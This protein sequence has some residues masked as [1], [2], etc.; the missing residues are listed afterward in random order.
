MAIRA[1]ILLYLFVI[2]YDVKGQG[3]RDSVFE[4]PQVHVRAE[5]IF[6]KESAGMRQ[7]LID[8]LTM[9]QKVNASLSELLSENTSVF[10]KNHGRGALATASFR[11]TAPSH[12]GVSWNGIN[13]SS[14]MTGM[15]DFALVPVYIMDE[16]HLKHGTASIAD[17]AGG[18]GGSISIS[19]RPD[20]DNTFST[21]YTQGIGSYKTYKE[22]LKVE[23]GNQEVQLRT[24]AYHNQSENNYTFLNR[25]IAD[26]E[27]GRVTHPVDTNTHADYKNYGLLQEVYLRPGGNHLVS[28]RWWGQWAQRTLPRATSF[29]GPDNTNL[30]EQSSIDQRFVTDWTFFTGSGKWLVRSGYSNKSLDYFQKNRVP[31]VG[32]LPAVYSESTSHSY[33]NH[34]AYTHQ[35]NEFFSLEGSLDVNYYD[36]DSRD[37]VSRAGFRVDRIEYSLFFALRHSFRDRLNVNLMVRQ[38][39]TD[40]AWDPIVPYAGFDLKISQRHNLILKGSVAR[41]HHQPSLNDLYW[42]PGGNPDLLPEKGMA[43]ELGLQHEQAFENLLLRNEITFYRSDVDDWI[44]WVPGF[45]GYWEPTNIKRV[46]SEGVEVHSLLEGKT[47][48]IAWRTSATYALTRAVNYG[49]PLV[50][51]DNSY[52][53]QLVYIPRHSGNL[54]IHMAWRGF[55]VNWQHNSYSERYTTSSNDVSRRDWLYPYHMN[56]VSLGKAFSI[57]MMDF[58]ARLKINNLFNESYHSVL[59]RPMP[60]RNYMLLLQAGF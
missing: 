45:K 20:W 18:L 32:L 44:I 10:I 30:N 37:S 47:A 8:S 49:D 33:L 24:R 52:G 26:V 2:L 34:A 1:I 40:N 9:Q 31:G 11:G 59:Y 22:Y 16:M 41:N 48:G 58:S 15:V 29:E 19:N 60:G 14:P 6:E 28:A 3:I 7:T 27:D 17:Q 13:I 42:Q 53:K 4:L 36:V 51:G 5:R 23:G 50:W 43:Y 56:N 21:H 54:L 12:T 35:V 25:A 55:Q 38:N 39:H 46:L 57:G